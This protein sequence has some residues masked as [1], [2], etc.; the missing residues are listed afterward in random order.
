M[1]LKKKQEIWISR[2]K[3]IAMVNITLYTSG[4]VYTPWLYQD[5]GP[6]KMSYIGISRI[7]VLNSIQR[8]L[9]KTCC[10]W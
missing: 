8:Y 3:D 9:N 1:L 7:T 4:K 5:K 2:E 10:L 6:I